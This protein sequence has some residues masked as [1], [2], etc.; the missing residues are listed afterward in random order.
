MQLFFHGQ[1]GWRRGSW[2]RA[3]NDDVQHG[4]MLPT[5]TAV[6]RKVVLQSGKS[7]RDNVESYY[8]WMVVSTV[9]W[10]NLKVFQR[11]GRKKHKH[12]LFLVAESPWTSIRQ[13][14]TLVTHNAN[15]PC[16]VRFYTFA[17]Q[18]LSKQLYTNVRYSWLFKKIVKSKMADPRWRVKW[19]R[20][21][22]KTPLNIALEAYN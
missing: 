10:V 8:G 22:L 7:L 13:S 9:S 19:R 18:P 5:Y 1:H 2:A 12:Y 16:G 15:R 14:Q 4:R 6:S 20:D 17:G 21:Q 3:S 11:G